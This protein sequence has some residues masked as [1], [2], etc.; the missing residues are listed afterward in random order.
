MCYLPRWECASIL[1]AQAQVKINTNVTVHPGTNNECL[2]L[3][4]L[5]PITKKRTINN[6]NNSLIKQGGIE[7]GKI[8][9]YGK[10]DAFMM[11][12]DIRWTMSWLSVC[13]PPGLTPPA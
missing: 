4:T 2:T 6:T 8:I 13:S 7:C 11:S 1:T 12:T 10:Y 9:C 5:V 3:V